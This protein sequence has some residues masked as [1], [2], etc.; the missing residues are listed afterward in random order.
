MKR[1]PSNPSNELRT[2]CL[3]VLG[4]LKEMDLNYRVNDVEG[5]E[6]VYRE[7][8]LQEL[9]KEKE[10]VRQWIQIV[11]RTLF[12][13]MRKSGVGEERSLSP[14]SVESPGWAKSEDFGGD[15]MCE[16]LSSVFIM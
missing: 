12:A 3:D 8:S 7:A 14:L 15:T 6:R 9:S 1:D 11:D 10:E 5:E 2:A 13:T 16:C 4:T